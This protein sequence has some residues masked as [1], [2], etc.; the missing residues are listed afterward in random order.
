MSVN[1]DAK[2]I[3]SLASEFEKER[4]P[5][6]K[7]TL[8]KQIESHNQNIQEEFSPNKK[9]YSPTMTAP[10]SKTKKPLASIEK[11]GSNILPPKTPK[12]KAP[13][14]KGPTISKSQRK[15]L[16]K[17]LNI[18]EEN[19]KRIYKKKKKKKEEYDYTIYSTSAY[20]QL[21]NRV[22]GNYVENLSK[23][24]KSFYNSIADSVRISGMQFLS[25][26][27]ISMMFFTTMIASFILGF[28][29]LFLTAIYKL[30]PSI[31]I[32]LTLAAII[33]GGIITF[34][35]M[36]AYPATEASRKSKEINEDLPFA[37]IHMAAIAGS[38]A[39]PISMFK[40]LLKSREYKGLESEIKKI[41]NLVNL[42]G[43]DLSTALKNV[44]LRTPSKS[45]K[46]LLTGIAATIESGGSLKSYL[47]SIAEDAMTTYRLKRKKYVQSL[48][49]YSDIYTGILIAAPL[50]FIVI[51]AIINLMGGTIGGVAVST[52]ALIGTFV[53]LPIIN[54]MFYL[55]LNISQPGE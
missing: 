34:L 50:L 23:K 37:I 52:I 29:T 8:L 32:L 18:N 24:N 12:S 48:S 51:L 3:I 38:G 27:Y 22:F 9:F 31:I 21:S 53:A 11:L 33:F 26:T 5:T 20:A 42:F 16:I 47:T 17:E 10:P 49:T 7:R 54:I 45:L 35:A 28:I 4:D 1:D 15:K 39:K 55:F 46:D 43:Y 36:Y 40:L 19:I 41:V 6:K 44:S 2:K 13:Q 30:N 14:P 25:R